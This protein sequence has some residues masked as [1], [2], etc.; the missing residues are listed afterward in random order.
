MGFSINNKKVKFNSLKSFGQNTFFISPNEESQHY[1]DNI[2]INLHNHLGYK[3]N[4]AHAHISIARKLDEM[5]IKKAY[6]SFSSLEIN[7]EFICDCIYI[8]KFNN[9][10]KQYTDI[11]KK[12]DF[13]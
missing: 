10:T 13:K 7:F 9:N 12:I 2:I 1:L 11:I 3:I 4:N 8:R 6:Q 5:K